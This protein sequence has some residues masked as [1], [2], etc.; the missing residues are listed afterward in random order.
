MENTIPWNEFVM[1]YLAFAISLT[2]FLTGF[3]VRNLSSSLLIFDL[4]ALI[5]ILCIFT[6]VPLKL[7]RY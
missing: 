4:G 3:I 5:N 7:G 2:H 1:T 6:S